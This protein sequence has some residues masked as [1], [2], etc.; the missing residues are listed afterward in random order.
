MEQTNFYENTR[1]SL[2]RSERKTLILDYKIG[3]TI[4]IQLLKVFE[5]IT[6]PAFSNL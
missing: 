2:E 1:Y 5:F 6:S 4:S 3:A